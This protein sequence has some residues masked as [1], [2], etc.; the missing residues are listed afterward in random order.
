MAPPRSR[1]VTRRQLLVHGGTAYLVLSGGL[2]GRALAN[3]PII[4]PLALSEARS[5]TMSSL[6][7]GVAADPGTGLSPDV[8][9]ATTSQF[10]DFYAAA[11]D[12]LRRDVDGTLDRVESE[13]GGFAPLSPTDALAVLGAWSTAGA[14]DGESGDPHRTLA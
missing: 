12:W 11:P 1:G 9:A 3:G 6:L 2:T 4:D 5:A 13:A 7:G 10:R 14:S 8:V